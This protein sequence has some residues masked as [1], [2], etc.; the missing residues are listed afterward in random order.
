MNQDASNGSGND[1]KDISTLTDWALKL[2]VD[3]GNRFWTRF[4]Q[5]LITNSIMGASLAVLLA[6]QSPLLTL[7][8][9]LWAMV[10]IGSIGIV[11]SGLW[12]EI[13]KKGAQW[14]SHYGRVFEELVELFKERAK[15]SATRFHKE[16]TFPKATDFERA[17]GITKK[18]Y[19]AVLIVMVVWFAV[20]TIALFRLVTYYLA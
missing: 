20:L 4:H 7:E 16:G 10:I 8:F 1:H 19:Y 6:S 5:W 12:S 15:I 18:A 14:H 17:T 9:K 2:F 11:L 13:V 3:E